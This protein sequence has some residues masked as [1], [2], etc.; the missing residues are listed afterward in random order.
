MLKR[1]DRSNQREIADLRKKIEDYPDLELTSLAEQVRRLLKRRN[2]EAES[3]ARWRRDAARAAQIES[4]FDA[5]AARD[6]EALRSKIIQGGKTKIVKLTMQIDPNVPSHIP[7][8]QL[9][10]VKG[11]LQR[12]LE[13]VIGDVTPGILQ[14]GVN[15]WFALAVILVVWNRPENRLQW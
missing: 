12:V 15:L 8:N 10:D 6:R 1:P 13:G 11:L 2:E 4:M 14:M 9:S 3:V 7:P 5:N